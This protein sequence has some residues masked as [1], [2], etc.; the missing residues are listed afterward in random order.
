MMQRFKLL[1]AAAAALALLAAPSP[2][3]AQNP[4]TD[5]DLQVYAGLHAAAA[6]GDVAEIEKLIAE[7]EKVNLQDSNSRTPLI[8]AAFRKQHAAA[9]ALLR[10]GANAN[11]RDLQGYDILTIAAVQ[12]DLD[13]VKI[14]LAQL[15]I[16][17]SLLDR[18][19]AALYQI[20]RELIELGPRELH[21]KVLWSRRVSGDKRQADRGLNCA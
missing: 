15:C 20:C 19:Y 7:G 11:A 6:S 12:N 18:F 8:V 2:L 5:R 9:Q 10:L 21:L 13:L 14:A 3:Q 1:P 17:K 16:R 4:P